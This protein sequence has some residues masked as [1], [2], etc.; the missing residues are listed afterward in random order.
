MRRA[1]DRYA[2]RAEIHR[3]GKTLSALAT[4]NGL[5]PSAC[6]VALI[7]QHPTGEKTISEFLGVEPSVLWP[8]RYP[9]SHQASQSRST[10][11]SQPAS[12]PIGGEL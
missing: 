4:E 6:R 8:D 12:S 3:R 7:R 9:S 2:I 11:E 1:W 5:E 10:A